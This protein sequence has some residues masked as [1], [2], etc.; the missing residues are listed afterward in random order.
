MRVDVVYFTSDLFASATGISMLSLMEN[1]KSFQ[2][3]HFY[4]FED[5]VTEENK[6]LLKQ[7]VEDDY[8]R[9]LTFLKM[10]MADECFDYKF[11]TK[12]YMGRTYLRLCLDKY[13][14]A[15]VEK[16]LCLDSDTLILGD[17][18]EIWNVELGENILAGVADC[19]N[20][21]AYHYQFGL[22]EDDIY[23]NVGMSIIDVKKWRDEHLT[24]AAK[25][26]IRSKNGTVFFVEQTMM[27]N[28]CRNRIL[29]LPLNYNCY[30]LLYAFSYDE[31][32]KMRKPNYFYSREEVE[33]AKADPKL[34]HFTRNFFMM[35]RPWIKG[36]DHSMT[37]EYQ[38]Y[39]AMSYWPELEED[40][41]TGKEKIKAAFWHSLPRWFMIRL[42][43]FLYNTVRPKL[44]WKNA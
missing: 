1:N 22:D 44:I 17:L 35:S 40:K 15:N 23:I 20:L 38:K 14:P 36:C 39:K 43:S 5:G 42:V 25:K 27:N 26:Y 3:I 28:I 6:K 7:T 16:V 11:K 41:R 10:P 13:L 19:L 9:K 24:E 33:A 34:I 8:N 31:L 29:Q 18:S 4:V 30:T 37:A 21:K 12:Y 2:D 32:L